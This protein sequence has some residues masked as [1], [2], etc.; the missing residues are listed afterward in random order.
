[1]ET[2]VMAAGIVM[3]GISSDVTREM[4]MK[5]KNANIS[6]NRATPSKVG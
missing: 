1:M 5:G 4:Q 6:T 3:I 2:V